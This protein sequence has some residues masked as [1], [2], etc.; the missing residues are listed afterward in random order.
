MVQAL[1]LAQEHQVQTI[2]PD[3]FLTKGAETGQLLPVGILTLYAQPASWPQHRA[4]ELSQG[5]PLLH[6]FVNAH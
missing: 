3:S 6:I 1:R 5:L 4:Q 2:A